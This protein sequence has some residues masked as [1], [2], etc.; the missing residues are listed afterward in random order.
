VPEGDTLRILA[1]KIDDR[2][3]GRRVERSVFRDPRLAG[4]DLADRVLV[5]ADA[6]GKH[7]FVRFDDGR[8]LH[9]HLGM[10][11]TFA[12]ARRST[13][14][15]WKRRVELWLDAGSLIGESVPTLELLESE[16]EH[17]VTD[18]LGPDLCARSG[19]PDPVT[20][21]ESLGADPDRPLAEVLL[22]QRL[23]AG[24]GNVYANDVPFIA[25][26]AP[27]QPVGTIDGLDRLV[28]L[29]TALIR[30]NAA[31][32]RQNTV[33]R[34]LGTD[35]TWVHGV[36]RRPCPVCGDRLHHRS[37]RETPWRRSSTWCPTCQPAGDA[38]TADLARARRLVALH[39]ATRDPMFPG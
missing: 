15:V 13:A 26:V 32:G 38:V 9:A 28:A 25:G 29:G 39:P 8:S 37:E 10:D 5:D 35:A 24:F 6:Y 31:L 30:T 11:G 36:G 33:G 17:L 34:R 2:L 7:L 3:A 19:A 23:V 18:R 4:R 21:V 16:H 14:P 1:D 27:F 22:D 12:V 20:V